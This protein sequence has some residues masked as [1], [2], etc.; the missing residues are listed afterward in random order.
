V[1]KIV[2]AVLFKKLTRGDL[3]NN[4]RPQG[5]VAGGGG[6]TYINLAIE[7]NELEPFINNRVIA[8]PKIGDTHGRSS[9]IIHA[10]SIYDSEMVGD[11]LIDPRTSRLDYKIS[12]TALHQNRHPAWLNEHTGFPIINSDASSAETVTTAENLRI[13]IARTTCGEYYAGYLNV[14]SRPIDWPTVL[15][16]MFTDGAGVIYVDNNELSP[17]VD[18]ETRELYETLM[19]KTNLLLYGPPGTGKTHA[20]QKLWRAL[21]HVSPFLCLNEND[22]INPFRYQNAIRS[23]WVTFHQNYSYEEFVI[24]KQVVPINGG[25]FTLKPKLGVFLDVAVS[26][27]PRNEFLKGIIFIDEL[28]RGNVSRILGQLITFLEKNKRASLECGTD[29][30][31]KLPLPLNDL[32]SKEEQSNVTEDLITLD[33][34]EI[35]LPIPYYLPSDIYVVASMNSVDKAVA[36]LDSALARRFKKVEYFADYRLLADLFEIDIDS[37]DYSDTETWD[38]KTIA[39]LLLRRLNDFIANYFGK[40]FE[41]GHVYFLQILD[42]NSED[43]RILALRECWEGLVYPQLSTLFSNRNELLHECLKVN[44][45]SLPDFYP[46]RYRNTAAGVIN[47]LENVSTYDINSIDELQ[48]VFR[49]IAR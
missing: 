5:S 33:N 38:S 1:A 48:E 2:D 6:Q 36:P 25:G 11:I 15:N 49:I 22:L 18:E 44:D 29:N 7:K 24:G 27:N 45:S 32:L 21:Q 9:Y 42:K 23:E 26:I 41:L 16:R 13:Y 40:D 35:N 14:E 19:Q 46:Y 30:P 4:D 28:N 10:K 37:I 8:S 31:L 39:I 3:W 17:E 34:G 47:V 43:E 12:R 20:M